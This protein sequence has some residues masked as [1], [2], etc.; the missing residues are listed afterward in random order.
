[1]IN[2]LSTNLIALPDLPS[3]F[4][5]ETKPRVAASEKLHARG[6]HC[7]K[8]MKRSLGRWENEGGAV[9]PKT[10]QNKT[11]PESGQ[12]S[13]GR[14]SRAAEKIMQRNNQHEAMIRYGEP[15]TA[16][17]RRQRGGYPVM[18]YNDRSPEVVAMN[19]HLRASSYP[20]RAD[21]N[22][23]NE[24]RRLTSGRDR[25]QNRM[26]SFL[27]LGRQYDT[28]ARA[29]FTSEAV[30]FVLIVATS[31]WPIINCVRALAAMW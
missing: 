12:E 3:F 26:R 22:R 20:E 7:P 14:N 31:A 8:E 5:R 1:M 27:H 25:L 30:F 9:M 6:A 24:K 28:Q 23:P 13:S 21:E 10:A 4:R 2:L 18:S 29:N 19:A 15:L 17:S 16:S 11:T